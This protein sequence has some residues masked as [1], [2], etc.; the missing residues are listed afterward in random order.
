MTTQA[1][2]KKLKLALDIAKE[3]NNTLKICNVNQRA[4]IKIHEREFKKAMSFQSGHYFNDLG[5]CIRCG[6][7]P[8]VNFGCV[9]GIYKEMSKKTKRIETLEKRL[10]KVLKWVDNRPKWLV[11]MLQSVSH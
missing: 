6:Y 11:K 10:R 2:I 4:R 3:A 1:R 9:K 8:G 7:P 5:I